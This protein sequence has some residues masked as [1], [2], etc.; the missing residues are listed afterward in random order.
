MMKIALAGGGGASDSRLL[1][2]VFA[3]WLGSQGKLL[4]WP[5]ALRGMRPFQACLEWIRAAFTPLGITDIIMWTDLNEHQAGE[6]D[7]LMASILAV[8]IRS[9]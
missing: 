9:P 6:L 3:R 5:L 1:D 2:E 8:G 7:R 4:Y